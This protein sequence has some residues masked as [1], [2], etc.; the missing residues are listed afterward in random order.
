VETSSVGELA[1]QTSIPY[2][3]EELEL[4]ANAVNWKRY[5]YGQIRSALRGH[6]LEVGAGLGGTTRV[7]C[8][9]EA[10]TWTALE[11]DESLANQMRRVAERSPYPVPVRVV[12]GT[13]AALAP[14]DR[15]DAIL[16]M[17]VLEH[18]EDDRGEL[19]RSVA[20][21]R[22]G[23]AIIA[24]SPAH[25]WLFSPFDARI[26]H[27]RRYTRDSMAAISPPGCHIERLVYLD[28]VGIV[29]SATNRFFLKQADPTISQVRFWDRCIVPVSRLV[30]PVLGY[31]FGKSVLVV[32][33]RSQ[34][35]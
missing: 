21:L 15:Y 31:R 32:W 13:V 26:G 18:I 35:S 20:H 29:A 16:Y 9:R 33:R 22:E 11:P 5:V 3:G 12:T 6:V 23:G 30:D 27:H 17:D 7:F 25:P 2:V 28:T 1:A 8:T 19:C 34:S 14:T 4:F 24:L 10:K